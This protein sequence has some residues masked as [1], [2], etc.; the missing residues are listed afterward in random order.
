MN[1]VWHDN[2][3]R[4]HSL[5][6]RLVVFYSDS[7]PGVR[8]VIDGM[9]SIGCVFNATKEIANGAMQA[10]TIKRGNTPGG[11]KKRTTGLNSRAIA[12][13]PDAQRYSLPRTACM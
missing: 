6:R 13:N 12:T 1:C 5:P 9:E 2:I 7:L 3:V 11:P 10:T 8:S 4:Y